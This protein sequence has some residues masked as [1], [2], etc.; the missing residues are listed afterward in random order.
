MA[1]CQSIITLLARLPKRAVTLIYVASDKQVFYETRGFSHLKTGMGPFPDPKTSKVNGYIFQQKSITAELSAAI[2][3]FRMK[4]RVHR[5]AEF[6]YCV[7]F[8]Q[9]D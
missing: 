2:L 5:C 4:Y 6:F 7:R 1:T 9:V 8:F 3:Y